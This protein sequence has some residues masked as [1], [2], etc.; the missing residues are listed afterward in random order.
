MTES[1]LT[2]TNLSFYVVSNAASNRNHRH[3]ILV[4]TCRVQEIG[5]FR[6]I[7]I[8]TWLR[9]LGKKTKEINYSSLNLV[10]ISFVL[11]HQASGPIVKCQGHEEM[12]KGGGG[13][14]S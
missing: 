8:L 7:K 3:H 4:F 10:V 12:G 1:N 6:Y 14:I 5:H 11:F 2:R 13:L 9:G